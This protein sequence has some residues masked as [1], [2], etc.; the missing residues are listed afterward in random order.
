[1]VLKECLYNHKFLLTTCLFTHFLFLPFFILQLFLSS[2]DPLS[3]TNQ[4]KD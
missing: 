1:M 4:T 2:L 3:Y